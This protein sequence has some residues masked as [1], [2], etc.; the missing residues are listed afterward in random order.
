MSSSKKLPL[1]VL[2]KSRVH[3]G[4]A[5]NPRNKKLL[6]FWKKNGALYATPAG[7]NDD[8]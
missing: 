2:H 1:I 6:E 3:G 8:W 5:V 4:P 7:S